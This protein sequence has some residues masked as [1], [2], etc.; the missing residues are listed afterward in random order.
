MQDEYYFHSTKITIMLTNVEGSFRGSIR[1]DKKICGVW[2]GLLMDSIHL[3]EIE[4]N[5]MQ[6]LLDDYIFGEILIKN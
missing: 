1:F 5:H 2:D 3:D 4:K 6:K